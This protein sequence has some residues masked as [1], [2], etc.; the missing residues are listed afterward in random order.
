MN[1]RLKHRASHG[2]ERYG[3]TEQFIQRPGKAPSSV[4]ESVA[5]TGI[6]SARH[7]TKP[8]QR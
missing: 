3:L 8:P 4:I 7:L 5:A 1:S 2:E 6:G